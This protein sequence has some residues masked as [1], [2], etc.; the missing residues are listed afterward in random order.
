LQQ[1]ALELSEAEERERRRI[2][3]LLHDNF[4]QQLAFIKMELGILQKTVDQKFA[5]T[6]ASLEQHAGECI[7]KSRK[8]SHEINPPVLHRSGMLAALAALAR[9][10]KDKDG[11]AVNLQT[12]PEAEPASL[13]L[14]SILYRSARELLL[15][16]V[17]HAGV[18]HAVVAV[19]SRDGMIQI[20]VED[21]GTG[22]DYQAV[23]TS[24]DRASG[25][26]LFSIEERMAFLGGTM[27]VVTQPGYGCRVVLTV[28]ILPEDDQCR[29]RRQ[30]YYC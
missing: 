25:F 6:L 30:T 27:E 17:K 3:S 23:R 1:L 4:Q 8:L 12:Q 16:V 20:R 29:F 26:G 24:E 28:P 11:F 9:D 10:M 19:S 14:R 7:E 13:A 18:N 2:S 5:K 15:N 21:A 22:F